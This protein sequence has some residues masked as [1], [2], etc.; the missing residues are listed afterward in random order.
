MLQGSNKDNRGWG[1]LLGQGRAEA[2]L[3]PLNLQ[4]GPVLPPSPGSSTRCRRGPHCCSGRAAKPPGQLP[5]LS[6]TQLPKEEGSST[7]NVVDV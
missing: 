1:S 7:E 2:A 3:L 6:P 5:F 4:A